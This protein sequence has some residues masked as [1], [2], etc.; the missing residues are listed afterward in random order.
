MDFVEFLIERGSARERDR[1]RYEHSRL[2]W[3]GRLRDEVVEFGNCNGGTKAIMGG[4]K[5]DKETTAFQ[6]RRVTRR[7]SPQGGL[8]GFFTRSDGG[9]CFAFDHSIKRTRINLKKSLDETV[10][11]LLSFGF[12]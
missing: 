12:K 10:V 5:E 11:M 1:E 2:L 3:Y 9:E 4:G 6:W 8:F 7:Q